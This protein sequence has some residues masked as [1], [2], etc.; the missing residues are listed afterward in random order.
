M[1]IAGFVFCYFVHTQLFYLSLTL[2]KVGALAFGGGFTIIPLIQ[3]DVVDRYQWAT[4]KE[5]LDGIAMGQVTPGPV[6]ITSTFLGYKVAGFAGAVMATLAIF[7]PPFFLISLLIPYYDRLK[8]MKIIRTMEQGILGSF[9][10]MLGLVLLIFGRTTLVDVP[11]VLFSLGAFMA[12][13]KKIDLAYILVTG[14][15]LS[16]LVFAYFR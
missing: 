2:S 3:Y 13:L 15:I 9:I 6:M 14:A 12:L 5:F 7:S 11:S 10:G 16:V 4:T 1:V 8:E